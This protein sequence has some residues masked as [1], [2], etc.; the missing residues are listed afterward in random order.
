MLSLYRQSDAGS[1][2][3]GARH[4]PVSLSPVVGNRFRRRHLS[5]PAVRYSAAMNPRKRREP[6]SKRP[7]GVHRQKVFADTGKRL[8]RGAPCGRFS[9]RK[10]GI[11]LS[12]ASRRISVCI[13]PA[14]LWFSVIR[15][16]VPRRFFSSLPS[17]VQAYPPGQAGVRASPFSFYSRPLFSVP[18]SYCPGARQGNPRKRLFPRRKA[19]P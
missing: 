17:G 14:V 13:C 5:G 11:H 8:R 6:G 9:F 1:S 16:A 15:N 4:A 18:P 10:T 2:L 12:P 19:A 7:R 3:P